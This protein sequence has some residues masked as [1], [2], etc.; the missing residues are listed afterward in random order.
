MDLSIAMVPSIPYMAA[1][2]R[3]LFHGF[4][5][6]R[7]LRVSTAFLKIATKFF[8]NINPMF[9]MMNF[10]HLQLTTC[11]ERYEILTVLNFLTC[12]PFVNTLSVI[13]TGLTRKFTLS[14]KGTPPS[15]AFLR[16]LE[17]IKTAALTYGNADIKCL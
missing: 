11:I 10:R 9:L 6:T 17:E 1:H 2:V 12:L 16:A 4:R 8:R 15:S 13:P 5:R 14:V 3:Q 7:I